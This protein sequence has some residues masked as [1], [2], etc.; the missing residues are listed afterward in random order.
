[1]EQK[2][3][4]QKMVL[5]DLDSYMKKNETSTYTRGVKLIFTRGHISLA[6]AFKGPNIILGLF[7][8]FLW[9]MPLEFDRDCIKS[10]Y[11]FG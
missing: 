11:C 1:M 7:V 9:K 3:P 5:G 6:V 10:I 2:Q 4:L 8:L